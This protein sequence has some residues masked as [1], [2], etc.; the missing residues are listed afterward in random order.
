MGVVETFLRMLNNFYLD[1]VILILL[2]CR[3]VVLL[4]RLVFIILLATQN[5][6]QKFI[7]YI[8]LFD[9][10]KQFLSATLK[11]VQQSWNKMLIAAAAVLQFAM[12]EEFKK[13][14]LMPLRIELENTDKE[15]LAV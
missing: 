12:F 10:S 1:I 3:W 15:E 9:E 14:L 4:L 13:K 2:C 7:P 11:S 6:R 5:C 8:C